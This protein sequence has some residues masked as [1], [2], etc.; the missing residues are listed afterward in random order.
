MVLAPVVAGAFLNQSFPRT[1]A[2]AARLTPC[3]ATLL[4]A[5]IVG[6]TLG[7]SAEAAKR[8][9]LHL[10]AVVFTLHGAG[11]Y[12]G[13]S[14]PNINKTARKESCEMWKSP[15]CSRLY[16]GLCSEQAPG[17]QQ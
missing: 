7:H 8:C 14:G 3:I 12:V 16:P 17:P 4:I 11:V 6:S 1:V 5:L 2:R 10:L 13:W 15:A 9:G